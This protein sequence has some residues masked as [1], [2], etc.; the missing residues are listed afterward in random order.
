M[1]KQIL[2]CKTT[3]RS[4]EITLQV[5]ITRKGIKEELDFHDGDPS[6]DDGVNGDD[7]NSNKLC[8]FSSLLS[9]A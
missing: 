2:L 6:D 7:D 5:G 3:V 1:N 4:G 9:F 8:R